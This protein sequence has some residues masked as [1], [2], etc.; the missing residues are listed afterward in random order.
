MTL[1]TLLNLTASLLAQ[2]AYPERT[3]RIQEA[4]RSYHADPKD[5]AFSSVGNL[6]LILG[7]ILAVLVVAARIV[8]QNN[9]P[10]AARK[11]RRFFSYMLKQ[12]GATYTDRLLMHQA[13]HHAQLAQPAMM[14]LSPE[15]FQRYALNWADQLRLRFFRQRV[16]ARFETIAARAFAP[17]P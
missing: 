10:V 8:R 16:R 1:T 2:R 14:L 6:L 7:I 4:F 9:Q 3:L 13:A 5:S 17:A 15:L 12:L 11:P